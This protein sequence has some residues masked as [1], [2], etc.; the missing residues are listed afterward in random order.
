MP[1][2][3]G[4]VPM[5]SAYQRMR[6][7]LFSMLSK[8]KRT[9]DASASFHELHQSTL[10]IV[11]GTCSS[12]VHSLLSL[13]CTV[14]RR[15]SRVGVSSG[16]APPKLVESSAG[17]AEVLSASLP[18]MNFTASTLPGCESRTKKS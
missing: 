18:L 15:M 8:T 17:F 7:E 1:M 2:C 13:Q 14:T 11:S 16:N 4:V 10:V 12:N 5:Y 6:H 3:L 9:Q